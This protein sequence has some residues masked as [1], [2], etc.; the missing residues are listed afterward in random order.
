MGIFDILEIQE[1]D[2]PLSIH[3][4]IQRG[5]PFFYMNKFAD[6]YKFTQDKAATT[7]L[8]SESTLYRRKK[9]GILNQAESDTLV[10]YIELYALADNVL[11]GCKNAAQWMSEP[12]FSLGDKTPLD[13]AKT[14]YGARHVESLLVQIKHGISA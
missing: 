14:S 2:L 12:N 10:R 9:T 7:I 1:T 4:M 13:Y 6:R 5:L 8:G 11:N 3:N